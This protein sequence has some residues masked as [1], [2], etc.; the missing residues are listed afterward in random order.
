MCQVFY[1]VIATGSA[2]KQLLHNS[3]TSAPES[4]TTTQSLEKPLTVNVDISP[5]APAMPTQ[6][7]IPTEL[8]TSPT[9]PAIPTQPEIGLPT[10][11]ETSPAPA[12]TITVDIIATPKQ[13]VKRRLS[14]TDISPLPVREVSS[15]KK[16]SSMCSMQ[17]TVLTSSPYKRSLKNREVTASKKTKG[18][19]CKVSDSTGTRK[20]NV[21]KMS[22]ET[23]N[24]KRRQK[25]QSKSKQTVLASDDTPCGYCKQRY[26]VGG[27]KAFEDWLQC[28]M[29][30]TWM[31]ES[32]AE[33]TGVIGDDGFTC[34]TCCE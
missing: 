27:E 15:V 22:S 29:C 1:Y 12:T 28:M 34:G 20:Q 16:K 6:C 2:E 14:V 8:E 19:Q 9:A 31:H 4:A 33:E 32:C 10:Q 13:T 3:T 23:K 18:S 11:L 24:R 30:E 5:A 17:A 7:E 21:S 26:N 25:R